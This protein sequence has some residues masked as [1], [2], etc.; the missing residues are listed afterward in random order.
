MKT[1]NLISMSD[2]GREDLE[3]L[4]K[5]ADD[6][7]GRAMQK[8]GRTAALLFNRPSTRT[9]LS[10]DVAL[11]QLGYGTTYLDYVFTQLVRGEKLKDS[12][13]TLSQYVDM[14]IA[15]LVPHSMLEEIVAYSEVP[16]INAGS[17]VE[18]PC[19]ALSD[20]Y[21]IKEAMGS[22]LRGGK[23]VFAGDPNDAVANSLA[24]ATTKLGL[25]FVYLCP[26][27]YYPSHAPNKKLEVSSDIKT[28]KDA[29]VIYTNAWA[30]ELGE[31]S[32]ERMRDFLPYQV[33]GQ[34][35]SN[36]PK[37]VLVMHPLP[38]FRGLEISDEVL[39][40]RNSLVW[41][42]VKNRIYVQKAVITALSR[43]QQ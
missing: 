39:D 3:N 31:E 4:L 32:P 42:Q 36:A 17:D 43:G 14:I 20:I 23:M 33:N 6:L 28:V 21:T 2:L 12:A 22:T 38:A 25:K 40:G 5:L 13:K 9:H 35:L 37:D 16:V 24:I 26:K 29:A 1:R 19:Q 41:K 34:M 30:H 8:N 15:R 27:G 18:H 11:N 10:F 7:K